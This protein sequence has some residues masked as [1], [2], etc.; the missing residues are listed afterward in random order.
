[1]AKFC[2]FIY[3]ETT[4]IRPRSE[5]QVYLRHQK[6]RALKEGNSRPEARKVRNLRNQARAN[7]F[8][9][10]HAISLL[11]VPSPLFLR[12]FWTQLERQLKVI[13]I[14]GHLSVEGRFPFQVKR[15]DLET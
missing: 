10:I 4:T 8:R 5:H 14:I 11:P 12:H 15:L 1:M 2:P 3:A 13:D 7:I 6:L 9:S